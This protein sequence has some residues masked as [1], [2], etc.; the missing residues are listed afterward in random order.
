VTR[1]DGVLSV[2]RSFSSRELAEL[3]RGAAVD[4]PVWRRPGFRLVAAWRTDH[5]HR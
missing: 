3:L 2:R 4:A 1:R 5:A